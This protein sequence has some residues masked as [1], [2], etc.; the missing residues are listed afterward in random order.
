[1]LQQRVELLLVEQLSQALVFWMHLM[2]SDQK[3]HGLQP[4]VRSV[5]L[6]GQLIQSLLDGALLAVQLRDGEESHTRETWDVQAVV[7]NHKQQGLPAALTIQQIHHL[8]QQPSVGSLLF[9]QPHDSLKGPLQQIPQHLEAIP[10]R[11]RIGLEAEHQLQGLL[12]LPE[13][14]LAEL[15]AVAQHISQVL[16]EAEVGVPGQAVAASL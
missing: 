6:R 1:M 9:K 2:L 12:E 13:I 11:N 8:L 14:L 7:L 15:G 5:D 3:H 10:H 4:L 16:V